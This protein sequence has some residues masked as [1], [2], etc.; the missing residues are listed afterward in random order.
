MTER[1][2]QGDG[3]FVSQHRWITTGRVAQQIET[4]AMKQMPT[5]LDERR[6]WG[7]E[8]DRCDYLRGH[9]FGTGSQ[10]VDPDAADVKPDGALWM[11]M[12]I[13]Q[14][15]SQLLWVGCG[16]STSHP[17]SAYR[18]LAESHRTTVELSGY[19]GKKGIFSSPKWVGYITMLIE[20]QETHQV[21]F[22]WIGGGTIAQLFDDFDKCLKG[23]LRVQNLASDLL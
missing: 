5:S 19:K 15:Q 8:V 21:P 20:A 10:T 3:I 23:A 16:L 4:N 2:P 12:M 1:G 22:G 7:R 13:D 14:E 6:A 11:M 18:H 9:A 17:R